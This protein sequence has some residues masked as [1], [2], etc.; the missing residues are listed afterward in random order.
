MKLIE[1]KDCWEVKESIRMMNSE[2]TDT[3]KISLIE[4]VKKNRHW[5][6]Y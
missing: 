1:E 3:E 2:S 6:S 5:W 4:A